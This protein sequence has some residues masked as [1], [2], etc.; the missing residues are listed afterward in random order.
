VEE[1]GKVLKADG[2][3]KGMLGWMVRIEGQMP[4]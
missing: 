4:G 2:F 1:Y 3:N